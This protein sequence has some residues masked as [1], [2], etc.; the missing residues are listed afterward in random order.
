VAESQTRQQ[1]IRRRLAEILGRPDFPAFSEHIQ[2]IMRSAEDE[3]A[4]VRLITNIILR[5]YSLTLR[6][7]RTA[8]SP[9]YNRSGRPIHSVTHAVTLLGLE[10]VRHLAGSLLLF[11]H[12]R[13][14]S[15]GL[16]ELMLLSLLTANHAAHAAMLAHYPRFEEAYICGMYRNLGE[17]LAACYFAPEYMALLVEMNE[18]SL[19]QRDAAQQVFGFPLED[20]G[21][22]CSRH[23]G[24]P[25]AV[26]SSIRNWQPSRGAADSPEQ[27]YNLTSFA[28]GLTT[29]LHRRDPATARPRLRLL[30]DMYRPILGLELEDAQWIADASVSETRDTFATLRVPLDDLRLRRQIADAVAAAAREGPSALPG[31]GAEEPGSL[32]EKLTQEVEAVVTGEGEID[33]NRALMMVLETVCRGTG[34]ERAAFCLL[35]PERTHIQARLGLGEEIDALLEGFHFPMSG[36]GNPVHL[37]LTLRQDLFVDRRRDGRFEHTE[38]VRALKP[39]AFA[40]LPVVVDGVGIGCLYLDRRAA[41]GTGDEGERRW[42]ASLRDLTARAI[43]RSRSPAARVTS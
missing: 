13:A 19:T 36:P 30:V 8:N 35:T 33:L 31:A 17:V 18:R 32:L 37:A 28:H 29:A 7:L 4:S 16:K 20:L 43:T 6:L 41:S 14:A 27:L 34:F 15:P 11:E 26:T 22:A 40:L 12:Y 5:D 38:L 2:R 10:A 1:R 21:Q 42:L 25:D 3:D 24:M 9:A 23:W 39:R